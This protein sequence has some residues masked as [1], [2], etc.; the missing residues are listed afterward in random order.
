[1]NLFHK[2]KDNISLD[3]E[4]LVRQCQHGDPEAMS[5]LI[6]KYQDRIYNTILKI[7]SNRDDAAELTQDTFVKVL[8]SIQTFRGKSSFYTWLFRV[9]VNLTIN[10]CRRRFKLSPVSLDAT[11]ENLEKQSQRLASILADSEKNDP[12]LMAQNKELI[13]RILDSI[14][15]LPEEY[16]LILILRDIEQMSYADIADVLELE[17]GTVKSRLSRARVALRN[18]WETVQT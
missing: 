16:R 17:Y 14:G 4:T 5:C 18:L 6:V 9:A 7:C 10:H 3:D 2:H 1:M 13:Q 11:N 8:E 15:Q 12:A